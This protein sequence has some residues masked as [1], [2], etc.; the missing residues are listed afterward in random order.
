[1]KVTFFSKLENESYIHACIGVDQFSKSA[2]FCHHKHNVNAD[3]DVD[4]NTNVTCEQGFTII[5]QHQL[6]A[7][8]SFINRLE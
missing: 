1:M 8:E 3:V 6:T 7:K 4:A 5:H 2:F